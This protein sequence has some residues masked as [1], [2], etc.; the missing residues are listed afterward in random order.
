MLKSDLAT[1]RQSAHES[2]VQQLRP[3]SSIHRLFSRLCG[4]RELERRSQRSAA[5]V[6]SVSFDFGYR[7]CVDYNVG[8][9]LKELAVINRYCFGSNIDSNSIRR[10]CKPLRTQAYKLKASQ[11]LCLLLYVIEDTIQ[12]AAFTLHYQEVAD[13]I[14]SC[15]INRWSI[16]QHRT[17]S[18]SC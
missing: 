2:R 1:A 3:A 11:S 8:R 13:R 15:T 7:C 18:T 17:R 9:D 16:A 14:T 10:Q 6:L 4:R 5:Q 12:T